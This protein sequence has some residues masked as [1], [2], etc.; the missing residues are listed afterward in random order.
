[1]RATIM[2]IILKNES[3]FMFGSIFPQVL[4]I[5]E[6]WSPK[7]LPSEAKYRDDL[8]KLL[9]EELN[10]DDP[11]GF[12]EE[13]SIRKESGRH[14]ADIGIDG[15]IGIELKYNLNTKSKVD[16][17]FGQIDDYL[18]GYDSMILVLCGKTSLEHLDYLREKVRKMSP[19][20]RTA[21]ESRQ[22]SA[23]VMTL[24]RSL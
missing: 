23:C 9:R 8:L 6:E 2:Y 11:L 16:R 22:T 12:S 15:K 7:K 14:L 10:R 13:H 19:R 18:K 17:L 3:K 21:Q 1:L 20:A 24:E 5:I 4:E